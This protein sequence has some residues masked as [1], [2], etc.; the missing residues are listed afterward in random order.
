MANALLLTVLSELTFF[1]LISCLRQFYKSTCLL[2]DFGFLL[3]RISVIFPSWDHE[4][5]K[6]SSIQV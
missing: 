3:I 2:S 1:F 4:D 6:Y 5:W